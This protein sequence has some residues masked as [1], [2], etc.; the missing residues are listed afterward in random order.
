V[1]AEA[2]TQAQMVA[3]VA[4]VPVALLDLVA[5][6]S[7]PLLAVTEPSSQALPHMEAVVVAAVSERPTLLAPVSGLQ[8]ATMAAAVAARPA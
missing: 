7:V 8:V 3:L 6:A 4:L 1:L 5:L 2:L